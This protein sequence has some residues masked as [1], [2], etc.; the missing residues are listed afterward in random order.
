MRAPRLVFALYLFLAA[1]FAPSAQAQAAPCHKTMGAK[2]MVCDGAGVF[3]DFQREGLALYHAALLDRYDIDYRVLTE[4][5]IGADIGALAPAAF[6]AAAVG[7]NSKTRKGFLLLVDPAAGKV[8]LEVSAG[9]D[10][11]FTDGFVAYLQQRQMVPFFKAGRAADGILAT[12]EMIVTRA[13]DAAAGKAF[14]PPEQLPDNLAIGAGAQTDVKIGSGYSA[15]QSAAGAAPASAGAAPLQVVAQYHAALAAGNT[16]PDLPIYSAATR[17]MRKSW[18][19]T[20]A[21]MKNELEAYKKCDVDRE[22]TLAGKPLATVRYKVD[23]RKCAPYFLVFEDGAW[24][25][26]FAAMMQSIRFNIDNDWRFD[27]QK[28]HAYGEA[29]ADWDFDKHGYPHAPRPKRWGITVTTNPKSGVTFISKIH[30]G[31][32]AESMPIRAGDI[33]LS[34]DGM[35]RPNHRSILR[36]LDTTPAGKKL[37]VEVERAG[38]KLQFEITAP[39]LLAKN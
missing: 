27:F 30:T 21:Q 34:W 8:R 9:L 24:R 19:V 4:N 2:D 1:G 37:A 13:Q 31:T 22:I 29:F 15:P 39:P 12:T 28:P 32:P 35:A 38:Q 7:S 3:T 14:I 25:L 6:K 36:S 10:A 11:V 26:D 16:A 23:Q 33:V 20:P 5:G 18:V 17:E